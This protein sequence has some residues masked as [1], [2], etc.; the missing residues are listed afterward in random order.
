MREKPI[1][2]ESARADEK[3]PGLDASHFPF[4][5]AQEDQ[6]SSSDDAHPNKTRISD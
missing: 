6:K 5:D 3:N 4:Y 2:Q 1:A